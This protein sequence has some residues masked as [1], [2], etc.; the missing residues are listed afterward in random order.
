MSINGYFRNGEFNSY[1]SGIPLSKDKTM[2]YVFKLKGIS[3]PVNFDVITEYMQFTDPLKSRHDM[4]LNHSIAVCKDKINLKALYEP[5]PAYPS[6]WMNYLPKD[7]VKICKG[8]DKIFP[9]RG[10]LGNDL[11]F[12]MISVPSA[13]GEQIG[14][15][16]FKQGV[17]F[18]VGTGISIDP[19][20]NFELIKPFTCFALGFPFDKISFRISINKLVSEGWVVTPKELTCWGAV[21]F[22]ISGNNVKDYNECYKY[23]KDSQCT[24]YDMKYCTCINPEKNNN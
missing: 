10:T 16:K 3:Y 5:N 7:S 21:A 15:I 8:E 4:R 12:W 22:T 18:G 11:T 20:V 9:I 2:V 6:P 17:T 19:S 24:K 1:S 14:D 23:L 13:N